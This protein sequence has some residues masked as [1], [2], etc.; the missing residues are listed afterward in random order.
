[1]KGAQI[2]FP[3]QNV[4]FLRLFEFWQWDLHLGV[5]TF[6]IPLRALFFELPLT[7]TFPIGLL[8]HF[9]ALILILDSSHMQ[10]PFDLFYEFD[11][12]FGADLT[13][14]YS[15]KNHSNR[16][17]QHCFSPYTMRKDDALDT[18]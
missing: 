16:R 5:F 7:V 13:T 10:S 1:M 2:P 14:L 11:L 6:I 9:L 12:A 3:F 15:L 17:Q 18:I 8:S 4:S